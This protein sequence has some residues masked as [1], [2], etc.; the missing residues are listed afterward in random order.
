MKP[1]I[2]VQAKLE[3]A[4][5]AKAHQAI[6]KCEWLRDNVQIIYLESDE[7]VIQIEIDHESPLDAVVDFAEKFSKVL[8]NPMFK[9]LLKIL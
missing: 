5:V 8:N 6:D 4:K 3:P 1:I 7:P 2:Y 9:T